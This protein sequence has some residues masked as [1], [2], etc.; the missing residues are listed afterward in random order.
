MDNSIHD[1]ID[2]LE[3]KL[4]GLPPREK[5]TLSPDAVIPVKDLGIMLLKEWDKVKPSLKATK[6]KR[7]HDDCKAS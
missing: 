5:I 7:I 3:R 1:Y 2:E 4:A 6:G